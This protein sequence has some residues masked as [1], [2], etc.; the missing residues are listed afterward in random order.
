MPPVLE[1]L[2]R[3][4]QAQGGGR[5]PEWLA[6]PPTPETR[7]GRIEQ[8]IAA[9]PQNFSGAAVNRD[10]YLRRLDGLGFGN[11][12]REGYFKENQFFHPDLRFRVTFP[13][14]WDT[15]NGKQ[16][17]IAVS[18]QQGAMVQGSVANE[19]TADAAAR[20]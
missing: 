10:T 18:P 1:T 17:V 7:R 9:F 12:P 11:N 16:A 2:T 14:G 15:N 5:V 13:E 19:P 4:S 8:D 20:P 6:T 3:V